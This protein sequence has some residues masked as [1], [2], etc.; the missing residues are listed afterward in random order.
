MDQQRNCSH[1]VFAPFL[2]FLVSQHLSENTME[3][4]YFDL[5]DFAQWYLQTTGES[6]RPELVTELDLAEYRQYLMR[7]MKPSTVNRRLA[8]L[9]KW[10][11]WAQ[12]TGQIGR[13][14]RLPK[15]VRQEKLAPRAL[16]RKEQNA[17]L[18]A[19]ERSGNARDKALVYVLLFCGLRVGELVKLRVEDLEIKER[20]GRLAVK[21]K[22]DK[23]REVPVPSNVRRALREY[24][25]ERKSG[26]LFLGQRGP[27]TA[28][29]VQQILKKYAYWARIG[30]LTPHVLRHTCATNLLNKGVDLVK[31]AALLGHENLNTTA[32]YTRPTFEELAGAVETDDD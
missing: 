5:Q 32:Q 19:V 31:V 12:D 14:P 13:L 20:V 18:R 8:A 21:G 2:D 29:G 15:R 10:L 9:K 23:Y 24:L 25:G 26:P 11:S 28:R 7:C 16:N 22:G 30:H 3:A 17:L 4:Y 1:N 6:P 27:L